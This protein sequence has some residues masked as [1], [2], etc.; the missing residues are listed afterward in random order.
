M[1]IY[2]YGPKPAFTF[3]AHAQCPSMVLAGHL[4]EHT[5]FLSNHAKI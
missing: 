5:L 4:F 3:G 2:T 1:G